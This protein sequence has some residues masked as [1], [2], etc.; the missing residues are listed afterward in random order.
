MTGVSAF[1]S[2]NGRKL[3]VIGLE[4]E[5]GGLWIVSEKRLAL[6]DLQT[7][8]YDCA[9]ASAKKITAFL[10]EGEFLWIARTSTPF[11]RN[12]SGIEPQDCRLWPAPR[13]LIQF[14][15]WEI[16]KSPFFISPK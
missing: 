1:G 5:E 15:A 6:L 3:R 8:K 7:M 9:W 4:L 11:N 14:F 10:N 13:K 12:G 16:R 2:L